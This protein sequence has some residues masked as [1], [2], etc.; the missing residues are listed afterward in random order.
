MTKTSVT[1]L[2][3]YKKDCSERQANRNI[4]EKYLKK[5]ISK[6]N[7]TLA[8]EIMF[9][10]QNDSSKNFFHKTCLLNQGAKKSGAEVIAIHD[11]DALL[12]LNQYEE[13]IHAIA[14]RKFDFCYPY[15][16]RFLDVP[17]RE[18]EKIL[19]ILDVSY[20]NVGKMHRLHSRSVGGC[21][22]YNRKSFIAGGMMNENF[23]SWGREDVELDCRFNILG[24]RCTRISGHLF[25]LYHQRGKDSSEKNP[26]LFAN[27]AEYDKVKVMDEK[28]LRAYIKTC[29][30]I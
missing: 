22:F 19:K 14:E 23:H 17:R 27:H 16:G 2:I 15:D 4:V 9:I 7:E 21:V 3:P 20:L 26:N 10:D 24:Y 8:A 30:W 6:T 28:Q 12:P 18:K 25:H 13:A 11:V 1:F 29:G 5:F